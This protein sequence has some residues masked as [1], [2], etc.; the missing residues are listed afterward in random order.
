MGGIASDNQGNVALGF[1][2]SS[3]SISPQIRYAGRLATDPV[4]T[5]SGEQ[6]LFDGTAA[7][8]LPPIAGAITVISQSIRWTTALSTTRTSARR[9]PASLAHPD[10]LFRFAQCTAPQKGTAHFVVTACTGGAPI[11]NASVSIDGRPYGERFPMALTMR[12]SHPGRIAIPLPRP[13]LG[14]K[15]ATSPL[16]MVKPHP[17][18]CA[19]E[20]ILVPHQRQQQRLRLR[21][22]QQLLPRQQ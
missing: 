2:A 16:P 19:W 5:L 4:N 7:R 1:S 3:K 6:H 20:A 8:A 12:Y 18:A 21:L 14:L 9:R 13:G 17:S 11:S 22:P 10:R 15:Q